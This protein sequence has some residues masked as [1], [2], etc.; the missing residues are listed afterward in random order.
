MDIKFGTKCYSFLTVTAGNIW[1]GCGEGRGL[2]M[3]TQPMSGESRGMK[4]GIQILKIA[5]QLGGHP[6]VRREWVSAKLGVPK[7]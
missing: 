5:L 4:L 3:E 7:V 2:D 1:A 6:R